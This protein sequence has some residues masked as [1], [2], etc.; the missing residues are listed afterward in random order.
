[1]VPP[2]TIDLE[3]KVLVDAGLPAAG[4]KMQG[5]VSISVPV[6]ALILE[7][8]VITT[9]EVKA[10]GSISVYLVGA[11]GSSEP[12]KRT[13]LYDCDP[14][15]KES[16][17]IPPELVRGSTEVNLVAVFDQLAAYTPKLEKRRVRNAVYRKA[18]K[19]VISSPAV[20]IQHHQ[21]IPDYKAMLFP[22]NSNTIEVFRL[23][24]G[25]AEPA[26]QLDKVFAANPEALK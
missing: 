7:A 16:H 17:V 24:V 9:A 23:R 18:E 2:P 26:P 5:D 20:D 8:S 13:K 10:G 25:I 6:G 22:S 12:G 4:T 3:T 11:A 1:V 19:G 15:E 21:L 14:K